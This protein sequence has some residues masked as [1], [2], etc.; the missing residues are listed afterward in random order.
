MPKFDNRRSV[1]SKYSEVEMFIR[2]METLFTH[3]FGINQ[4]GSFGVPDKNHTIHSFRKKRFH[5]Y[6][7]GTVP[8][9]IKV[10]KN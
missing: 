5:H 4:I 3:G 1:I 7:N 2:A 10:P 9:K 8:I 6:G